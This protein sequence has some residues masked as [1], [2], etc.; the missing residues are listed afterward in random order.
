[1]AG[2]SRAAGLAEGRAGDG[3]PKTG[4]DCRPYIVFRLRKPAALMCRHR[5]WAG[6]AAV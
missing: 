4:K 1:M 5:R 2:S 6:F 3:V